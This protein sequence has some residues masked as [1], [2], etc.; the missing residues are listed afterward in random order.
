[1]FSAPPLTPVVKKLIIAL[2]ACFVTQV[3]I[4]F[5]RDG[6]NLMFKFLALDPRFTNPLLLLQMFSYVFVTDPTGLGRLIFS[7]VFMWL[8]MSRFESSFGARHTLWLMLVGTVGG[9][10]AALLAAVVAAP[11]IPLYGSETI[12][13][14][15]MSAMA[16][17]M[18]GRTMSLFGLLNVT[19]RQLIGGLIV[20]ALL[21]F[22]ISRD[23]VRFA[24]VLGAMLAG[25]GYVK[26]MGRAP[27]RS[28]PPNKRP[29]STR[30]RV[31]RGGGGGG[32]A[33]GG[34]NGDND[35]PKWLN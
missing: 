13:Y 18:A 11:R 24:A 19:P 3:L 29:G 30:F 21:D 22:L 25:G 26:Y 10:V 27:R 4:E 16:Q 1:M 12:A 9:S 33:S 32:G 2:F 15:G 6:G 35:R 17:V 34:G 20:L 31:L 14:A 28:S 5:V 7:L 23:H 8:I